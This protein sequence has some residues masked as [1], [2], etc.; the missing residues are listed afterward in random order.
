M[1]DPIAT[2]YRDMLQGAQSLG[3]LSH[4]GTLTPDG[5][6]LDAYKEALKIR[7]QLEVKAWHSGVPGVVTTFSG[8]VTP[9]DALSRIEDY[10]E[11]QYFENGWMLSWP[12]KRTL[13]NSRRANGTDDHG[14]QRQT[15]ARG[16]PVK[17]S[18]DPG[19]GIWWV[20]HNEYS[21]IE[22]PDWHLMAKNLTWK[23]GQSVFH[24]V[25]KDPDWITAKTVPGSWSPEAYIADPPS[26]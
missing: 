21:P 8:D 26:H 14:W 23:G 13:I 9:D 16:T 19:W 3:D 7:N 25:V 24:D 11:A 20:T 17:L 10:F 2:A 12:E 15:H 4:Q 6:I 18:A 5:I 22:R 1:S